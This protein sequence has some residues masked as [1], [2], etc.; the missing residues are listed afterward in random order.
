MSGSF[1]EP[2]FLKRGMKIERRNATRVPR[3]TGMIYNLSCNMRARKNGIL[4]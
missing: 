4:K 1:N 3:G 2:V